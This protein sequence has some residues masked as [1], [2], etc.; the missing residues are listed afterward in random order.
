MTAPCAQ[1]HRDRC[2]V[3][4]LDLPSQRGD[5]LAALGIDWDGRR[6]VY[7]LNG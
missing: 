2:A 1:I 5:D 6:A 4:V 3:E 7:P